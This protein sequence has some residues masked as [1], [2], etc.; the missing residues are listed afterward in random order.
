MGSGLI[1]ESTRCKS[2]RRRRRFQRPH[3][4]SLRGLLDVTADLQQHGQPCRRDRIHRC[5]GA[6]RTA[7]STRRREAPTCSNN[8]GR[9]SQVITAVGCPTTITP[10]LRSHSPKK[11]GSVLTFDWSTRAFPY[12]WDNYFSGYDGTF[13]QPFVA[14]KF[15]VDT[16]TFPDGQSVKF[17]YTLISASTNLLA[18]GEVVPGVDKYVLSQV[19]NSMGRSLTFNWSIQQQAGDLSGTWAFP[20]TSVVDDTGRR[21]H[22]WP[23][24]LPDSSRSNRS[25]GQRSV[26][27][28]HIHRDAPQRRG[29]TATPTKQVRILQIPPC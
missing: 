7:H 19:S 6:C 20:L 4:R 24:L 23:E 22:L 8:R 11:N 18:N 21:S 17:N 12:G 26:S 16:W 28:Q 15:K 3:D 2:W 9:R 29:R 27:V 10:G 5:S 25:F 13:E 14:P 1:T